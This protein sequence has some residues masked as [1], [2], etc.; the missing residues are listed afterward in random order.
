MPSEIRENITCPLCGSSSVK[1]EFECRDYFVSGESF[2]VCSCSE[3][4][5]YFTGNVPSGDRM[6][7]YYQSPK[8]I[9]H[10]DTEKGIIN[11]L[12]HLVRSVMLKEKTNLVIHFTGR[13]QGR[14]LDYGT[15][16]GYFPAR[17]KQR[18]WEVESVEVSENARTFAFEHFGL[19]SKLPEDIGSFGECSFDCI[20]LWHVLEHVA[21]LHGIMDEFKRILKDSGLLVIAVPNRT[22]YD[23]GKYGNMWAAYDVPRHLW[24][25]S[26]VTMQ[27]LGNEHGFGLVEMI[28]MPFDAFYIS[29]MSEKNSGAACP[30]L[31]GLFYGA[32]AWFHSLGKRERSSSLIYI[33]KKK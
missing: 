7:H 28:P 3:C 14:L 19:K 21:D 33:F 6:G 32:V 2:P 11:K 16:T 29:M 18:G 23:A 30:F 4:G 15:G 26:P 17:M 9:S 5:F 22:S 10:S 1:K 31:K 25:F 27:R 13:R 8:Y 12:Y 24:H 20:T